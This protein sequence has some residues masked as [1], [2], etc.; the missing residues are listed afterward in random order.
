MGNP[1]F[2]DE[3]TEATATA[4]N[5]DATA[6]EVTAT[7]SEPT[8]EEQVRRAVITSG[9]TLAPEDIDKIVVSLL[10]VDLLSREV[11]QEKCDA[12]GE[13]FSAATAGPTKKLQSAMEA[14]YNEFNAETQEALAVYNSALVSAGYAPM[15]VESMV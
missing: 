3:T 1:E 10:N 15:S 14:L 5:A 7:A 6:A 4:V 8:I 13:A 2:S 12:A 9:A 11:L